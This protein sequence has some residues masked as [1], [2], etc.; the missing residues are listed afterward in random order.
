MQLGKE[1][2]TG[3]VEDDL[4][5]APLAPPLA[6]DVQAADRPADGSGARQEL[7]RATAG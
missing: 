3:F 5:A 4:T 2:A 6:G 1:Q 7:E